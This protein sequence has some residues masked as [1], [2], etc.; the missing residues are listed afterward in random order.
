MQRIRCFVENTTNGLANGMTC[1]VRKL[2]KMGMQ[3]CPVGHDQES[4]LVILAHHQVHFDIPYALPGLNNSGAVLYGD[5]TGDNTPRITPEASLTPSMPM[6]KVLVQSLEGL[7]RSLVAMLTRPYPL[8]ETFVANG[9]KA[10]FIAPNANQF[11]APFLDLKPLNGHLLHA[12]VEFKGFGF[13][14]MA[15]SRLALGI[16]G[17][18]TTCCGASSSRIAPKF[19]ADG[20]RMYPDLLGDFF[21]TPTRLEEGLNLIP[22]FKTELGVVFFHLQCKDCTA[23]SNGIKGPQ[24][25]FCRLF[26]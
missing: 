8:I 4:A 7:M 22:L 16:S 26:S 1:F 6:T 18:I 19:P 17:A 13:V 14:G 21:L 2:M 23:R 10:G 20:R 24:R 25:S 9:A 15:F 3:G 5:S 11:R 12:I